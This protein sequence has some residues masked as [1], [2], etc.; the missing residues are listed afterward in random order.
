MS[1]SWISGL[2]QGRNGRESQGPAPLATRSSRPIRSAFRPEFVELQERIA[3]AV[4]II[5]SVPG[6]AFDQSVD[7]VTGTDSNFRVPASPSIAVGVNRM[8]EVV[9]SSAFILNKQGGVIQQTNLFNAFAPL[10]IGNLNPTSPIGALTNENLA[11]QVVYDDTQGRF[12]FFMLQQTTPTTANLLYAVSND[13]APNSFANDF[14]NFGSLPIALTSITGNLNPLLPVDLRVGFN[15]EGVF[16][17]SDLVTTPPVGTGSY[18]STLLLSINKSSFLNQLPITVGTNAQEFQLGPLNYGLAPA[19]MHNAPAG[20]PEIF[21]STNGI[22]SNGTAFG[23]SSLRVM[24]MSNPLSANATFNVISV[25]VANSGNGPTFDA[26]QPGDVLDTYDTAI[27]NASWMNNSLVA[28]QTAKING[29]DEVAWYQISTANNGASLTQSGDIDGG[30]GVYTFF[31]RIEISTRG[32]IGITYN[33]SS[34][35][36]F[37]SSMVAGRAAADPAGFLES[38]VVAQAGTTTYRDNTG[39]GFS[40][41][42]Y[43]GIGLDPQNP[44]A[45]YSIGIYAT[46]AMSLNN[47][48]TQIANFSMSPAAAAQVRILGPVRFVYNPATGIYTGNVVFINTLNVV[49]ALGGGN[50]LNLTNLTLVFNIP[51]P[52]IVMIAPGGVTNA[53]THQFSITLDGTFTAGQVLR[54]PLQ[55]QSGQKVPVPTFFISEFGDII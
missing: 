37:L 15:R 16:V 18:D 44:A 29:K 50:P 31:P 28:A 23:S 41:G 3:P 39:P 36:V 5:Q 52:S 14:S 40:P 24:Y 26:P 17:T 33:E 45:F 22:G 2:F 27:T 10:L 43:T 46:S 54:F 51:D 13:S 12:Y 1:F 34:A 32:D 30:A 49:S 11:E 47:W 42:P 53:I 20:S 4:N 25:G 9:N 19:T 35:T 55:Y 38:P 21:V 6:A 7:P 48:A 8:V